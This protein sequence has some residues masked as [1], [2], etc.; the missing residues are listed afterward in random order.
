VNQRPDWFLDEL[1][2]LLNTN[3]FISVH[4][5]T[6]HRE[7]ERAG[8]SRKKLKKFVAEKNELLR[9]DFIRKVA[10]Y[11]PDQL[12]FIDRTSKDERT[13]Q[14]RYGRARTEEDALVWGI[15]NRR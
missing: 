3:R 4:Y 10:N 11:T 9:S 12:I 2:E 1:L 15:I 7:L 13:L 6:I 5:T 8:M 14:R